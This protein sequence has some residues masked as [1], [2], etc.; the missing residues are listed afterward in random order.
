MKAIMDVMQ[1]STRS[2]VSWTSHD[3]AR[4][5]KT[6]RKYN[7]Q[8]QITGVL[9]YQEDYSLQHIEG[10]TTETEQVIVRII[11]NQRRENIA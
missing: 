11:K 2:C 7:T 10:H 4:W 3:Y 8:N 6:A 5:P 1:A 9:R